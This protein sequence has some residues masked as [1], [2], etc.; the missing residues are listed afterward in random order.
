MV[1]AT[2]YRILVLP[3]VHLPAR[4]I[5]SGFG[6]RFRNSRENSL[7]VC[8]GSIDR[9]AMGPWPIRFGVCGWRLLPSSRR[10]LAEF[11]RVFGETLGREVVIRL[12]PDHETLLDGVLLGAIDLA[13]MPSRI[14]RRAVARG[15][16]LAAV[17]EHRPRDGFF[18][19]APMNGW[20]QARLRDALLGL[21]RVARGETVLLSLLGA[22]RL[23]PVRVDFARPH[24]W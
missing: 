2:A 15:A 14:H 13:W 6:A 17:T 19:S 22:A 3:R 21:H 16:L 24:T 9:A 20:K 23:A 5:P 4:A 1:R 11:A 7:K 10:A 12:L 8:A 18:L